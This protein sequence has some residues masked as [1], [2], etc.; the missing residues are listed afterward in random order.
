[1]GIYAKKEEEEEEEKVMEW[2]FHHWDMFTEQFSI[3]RELMNINNFMYI[4]INKKTAVI[5]IST[6]TSINT[7]IKLFTNLPNPQMYFILFIFS[8]NV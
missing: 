3:V 1:M 7:D 2:F 4:N 5:N 8:S 6:L